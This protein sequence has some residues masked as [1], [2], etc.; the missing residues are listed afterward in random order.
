MYFLCYFEGASQKHQPQN[1]NEGC[2]TKYEQQNENSKCHR[3]II[4]LGYVLMSPSIE[5]FD[6]APAMLT[7]WYVHVIHNVKKYAIKY[8]ALT[9]KYRFFTDKVYRSR[10]KS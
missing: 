3:K 10:N 5:K 9:Y 8:H 6:Y 1:K 4:S 2:N 7:C